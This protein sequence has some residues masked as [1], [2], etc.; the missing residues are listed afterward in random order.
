MPKPSIKNIAFTAM[1]TPCSSYKPFL[2][3]SPLYHP[4]DEGNAGGKLNQRYLSLALLLSIG[5]RWSPRRTFCQTHFMDEGGAFYSHIKKP[6]VTSGL[7]IDLCYR[8][9]SAFASIERFTL[10]DGVMI[11]GF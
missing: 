4:F 3:V 6:A 7:L 9:Y 10:P 2:N 8:A 11:V 5:A 1:A